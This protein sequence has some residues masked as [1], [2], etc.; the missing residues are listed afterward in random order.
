MKRFAV[1]GAM[2]VWLCGLLPA[3]LHVPQ[4]GFARFSDGAIHI[5]HGITANLIVGA[6]AL[7]KA[8]SASF[9]D[10]GGLTSSDGLIRLTNA[11]GAVLGEYQSGE[12]QPILNIDSSLQSAVVWLPSKHALLG[13]DGT[14]FTTAAVDD[15]GFGGKVTFV[16]LASGKTVE[17]FVEL[18]HSS[19]TRLSVSLTEGRLINAERE[20]GGHGAVFVQQGWLLSQNERGLMGELPDGKR[21]TIELSKAPLPA[22]DLK[23]E[24]MSNNWLHV[25]SRSTGADWAVYLSSTKTSVSLLPPPARVREESR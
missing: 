16:R 19:V 24:R 21:Q 18:A 13:W 23:I 22:D 1:F 4:P 14:A 5:V 6:R 7:A 12:A 25:S 9:S 15:S 17:L 10:C 8:D 20:P 3:Q 11:E 2:F